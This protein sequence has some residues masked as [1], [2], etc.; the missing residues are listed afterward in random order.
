[1]NAVNSNS[2]PAPVGKTLIG[3]INAIAPAPAMPVMTTVTQTA[4]YTEKLSKVEAFAL[5][6]ELIEKGLQDDFV[7]GGVLSRIRDG[8]KHNKAW[9]DG[10]PDFK[11]LVQG[12]FNCDQR[13]ALYL[14]KNYHYLVKNNI[15]PETMKGVGWTKIKLLVEE[16]KLTKGNAAK[17][18]KKAKKLSV[19]KLKAK[20]KGKAKSALPTP[21]GKVVPVN[22][23]L[24]AADGKKKALKQE[25]DDHLDT[26]TKELKATLPT[27][28]AAPMAWLN[29]FE[30]AWPHVLV[31]VEFPA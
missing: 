11:S 19:F 20:V 7:K 4:L 23:E 1:M 31:K 18:A 2:L 9:L 25:V 26:V 8:S 6:D 24:V 28:D 27:G 16:K 12:R 30:R 21:Q 3:G 17:W 15:P 14:I 13:T 10:F 5:L 29:A 22:D